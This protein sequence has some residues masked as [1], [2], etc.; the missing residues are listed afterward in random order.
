M[1]LGATLPWN[2]SEIEPGRVLMSVARAGYVG[3][4]WVPGDALNLAAAVDPNLVRQ[5]G[6]AE[7]VRRILIEAGVKPPTNLETA[8]WRGTGLLTRHSPRISARRLLVLG[9]AAGYVEPFTGEG[10][11]WGMLSAVLAAPLI[12]DWVSRD[13]ARNGDCSAA[14]HEFGRLARAW[15]VLYRT[16]IAPRQRH[17]QIL[18]SF[19][20]SPT[21]VRA[22]MAFVA[23]AP[24]V[25]KPLIGHFWNSGQGVE[26]ETK[27]GSL[28]EQGLR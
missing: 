25:A 1:G 15:S 3:M 17:C 4:V 26:V 28:T 8:E 18:S 27:T 22:A 5:R 20:R 14:R 12:E 16:H 24:S 6:P 7:A 23:V 13:S 2:A 11:T 9:D 21:A 19:L 10:M